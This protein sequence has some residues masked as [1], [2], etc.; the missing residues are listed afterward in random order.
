MKKI[1]ILVVEDEE[2]LARTMADFLR[3]QGYEVECASDGESALQ[4]FYDQRGRIDLI[5]LDV[6]M[7]GMSGY[8]VLRE[9]RLTSD[10]P[11]ILLTARSSVEDQM[12]GFEKGAD[13]YITKPYT[14]ELV[15]LHIEAV[16]K[17]AG[18]LKRTLEYG[19]ISIDLA[20]Q[21][22]YWRGNYIET[23]RKEYELL[24]YFMENIG[25]VLRRNTILDAVW[26]YDYVGDM[27]T[28][29]TLVKQ[30]RRKLT[31]ECTYIKSIYGV[32]YIFGDHK[33]RGK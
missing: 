7:P 13:D 3:L 5:L 25:V 18:K 28:V 26:G 1:R 33:S 22:V 10:V 9:L 31:E 12:S 4:L 6:M 27:R 17:R 20:G 29:D 19:D 2:K 32:G 24:V 15:K 11:V 14:L 16:L 30:L 23:T 21:M 8:E